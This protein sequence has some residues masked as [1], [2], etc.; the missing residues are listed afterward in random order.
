VQYWVGVR[1]NY[2]FDPSARQ[3][4]LILIQGVDIP[5]I[6]MYHRGSSNPEQ[7]RQHGRDDR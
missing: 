1:R 4:M 7:R 3:E 2:I 6:D 5:A